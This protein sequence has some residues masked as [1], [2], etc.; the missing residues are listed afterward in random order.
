MADQRRDFARRKGEGKRMEQRAPRHAKT[1][2]IQRKGCFLVVRML[3]DN[4][5]RY[6]RI[7]RP[8]LSETEG[9]S[10]NNLAIGAPVAGIFAVAGGDILAIKQVVNVDTQR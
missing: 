5:W 3:H 2:V 4:P 10:T 1:D 9:C 7:P 6:G 8:F